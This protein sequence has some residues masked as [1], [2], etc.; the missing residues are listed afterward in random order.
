V[1][2]EHIATLRLVVPDLPL[3]IVDKTG[4]PSCNIKFLVVD[5][6]SWVARTALS[7]YT[8]VA[9]VG[10]RQNRRLPRETK[11][12]FSQRPQEQGFGA[13]GQKY[14]AREFVQRLCRA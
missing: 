13:Y 11:F 8:N 2:H 10:M 1:L 7:P 9:R 6:N 14:I 12:Q 5:D 4:M 3:Y